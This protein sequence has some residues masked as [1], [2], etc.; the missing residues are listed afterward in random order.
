MKDRG[1]HR[2]T[3]FIVY[4]Q[5]DT[6]SSTNEIQFDS[7]QVGNQGQNGQNMTVTANYSIP[8]GT[9][10]DLGSI[11]VETDGGTGY[12]PDFNIAPLSPATI[13]SLSPP[14]WTAN[15]LPFQLTIS[16]ANF[17]NSPSISI[18]PGDIT[19]SNVNSPDTGT[20]TAT[21]TVPTSE[22]SSQ[23]TVTVNP[24]VS[25]CT[26]NCIASTN[27]TNPTGQA[28]AQA[29][30]NTS[31]YSLSPNPLNLSTGDTNTSISISGASGGSISYAQT[32][33]SN[34]A[35]SCQ[36]SLTFQSPQSSSSVVTAS[37]ANCSGIFSI[38][39]NVN[40]TAAYGTVVVPPQI[41]I[42]MLYGEAHEQTV[43][44]DSVSEP[45]IGV[46]TQNRFNRLF[47]F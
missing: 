28:Q 47:P 29:S 4:F 44:G 45:A 17:G 5:S 10:E 34:N 8:Y 37:P 12:G 24:S 1:L 46:A 32:L 43:I 33:T 16:G 3:L 6:N 39:A 41:L 27:P 9:P 42:Q 18:S 40:S 36:V 26:G 14:S 25:G 7:V 38:Q 22:N 30:I 11:T 19:Y 23:A 31:Q 35:S 2:F 15:G 20:I 21:V 13:Y